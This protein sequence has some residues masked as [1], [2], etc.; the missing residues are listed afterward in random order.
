MNRFQTIG[1][2]MVGVAGDISRIPPWLSMAA[3]GFAILVGMVAGFFPAM[4]AMRLSP[5][6]AIRNE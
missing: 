5:L 4:R 2:M 3:V 6:A 1:E